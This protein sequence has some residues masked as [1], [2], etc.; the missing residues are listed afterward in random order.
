MFVPECSDIP[1]L[2]LPKADICNLSSDPTLPAGS[3]D[4]LAEKLGYSEREIFRRS[5]TNQTRKVVLDWLRERAETVPTHTNAR[6]TFIDL[7][8]GIGGPR[9]ALIA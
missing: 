6:F 3:T 5:P 2:Q 1:S 8:A 4:E 9:R 7:F